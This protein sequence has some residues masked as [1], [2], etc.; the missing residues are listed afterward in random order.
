MY[1]PRP[2]EPIIKSGPFAGR[3]ARTVGRQVSAIGRFPSAFH[4]AEAILRTE[5]GRLASMANQMTLTQVN[6]TNPGMQ[7]QWSAILDARTR[8]EHVAAHGQIVGANDKFSVGGEQLE[9]PRDP[10]GD[11]SNTVNCRCVALPWHPSWEKYG[12]STELKAP[13]PAEWEW[14]VEPRGSWKPPL[15]PRG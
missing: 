15:T 13:E 9:Y 10:R 11:P 12:F 6:R 2:G 14:R 3:A 1:A 4:R 7:K 8:P 5:M